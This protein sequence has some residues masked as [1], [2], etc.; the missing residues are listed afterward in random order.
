[1]ITDVKIKDINSS[2]AGSMVTKEYLDYKISGIVKDAKELSNM[3]Y[4]SGQKIRCPN[5][6]IEIMR[7]W[8]SKT[9]DE[10]N[11]TY[12]GCR[13]TK[14]T[15]PVTWQDPQDVPSCSYNYPGYPSCERRYLTCTANEWDAVLCAIP[16]GDG[17]PFLVHNRHTSKQCTD[18]KGKVTED[19]LGNK[20]CRFNLADCPTSWYQYENWSTTIAA[21]CSSDYSQCN[22]P[23]P[24]HTWSNKG[25][26]KY[27]HCLT[28]NWHHCDTSKQPN[29]CD[30]WKN[31]HTNST[32]PTT[33]PTSAKR[34]QIGCY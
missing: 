28:D 7:H 27:A 17:T 26:E 30:C 29:W 11:Y 20:M 18:A 34:T 32:Y 22:T 2:A 16:A 4:L 9:C 10:T 6:A 14:C 25:V 5:G 19:G 24:S 21:S 12:R 3:I 1:M 23:L 31:S 8:L 15:T 33:Y 13:G